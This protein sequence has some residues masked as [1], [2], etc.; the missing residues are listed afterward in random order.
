MKGWLKAGLIGGAALS[1]LHLLNLIPLMGTFALVC[2]CII[3]LA[4]VLICGGAGALAAH[5]L[6]APRDAGTAAGQGALAGGLAGLIGGAVNAVVML[7]Q[8]AMTDS[9]EVI[10]QLPPE[11]LDAMRE[12]GITTDVLESSTGVL[13]GLL[14]G[15]CCCLAGVIVALALGAIGGAIWAAVRPNE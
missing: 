13:G 15:G 7:I 8:S 5:W 11:M 1:V 12:A 3:M 10:S 6:P 9:A 2:C 14:G 4:Y